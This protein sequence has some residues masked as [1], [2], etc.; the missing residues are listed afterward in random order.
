LVPGIALA[1]ESALQKKTG[2]DHPRL[3]GLFD[4]VAGICPSRGSML[5]KGFFRPPFAVSHSIA[6]AQIIEAPEPHRIKIRSVNVA[7]RDVL[8]T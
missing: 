5:S 4:R 7:A 1:I 6:M 3:A 8:S 2:R